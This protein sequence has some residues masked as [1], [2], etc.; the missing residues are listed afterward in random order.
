MFN[1]LLKHPA[2]GTP[3]VAYAE[4][5]LNRIT[6]CA[7]MVVMRIQSFVSKPSE[8]SSYQWIGPPLTPPSPFQ[9]H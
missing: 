7:H 6:N 1:F 8:R 5:V 2:L 4:M 3:D 9:V